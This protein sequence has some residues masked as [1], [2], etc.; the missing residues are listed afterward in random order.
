MLNR[1]EANQRTAVTALTVAAAGGAIASASCDKSDS[2]VESD[3]R[4]LQEQHGW[5][6]GYDAETISVA[7]TV[8]EDSL[9]NTDWAERKTP[10]AMLAAVRPTTEAWRSHESPALYQALAQ[11]T[12]ADGIQPISDDEMTRAYGIG[13]ALGEL[14]DSA[15]NPEQALLIID[16][17]GKDAVACAAGLANFAEPVFWMDNW[18]HPRGVVKSE[19]AL[20]STLYYAAELEAAQT[21]REAA[22]AKVIVLDSTRLTPYRD[23]TTEFDNRY[24]AEVPSAEQARALGIT[25]VIYVTAS[26]SSAEAD[27]LNDAFVDYSKGMEVANVSLDQFAQDPEEDD[28]KGGGYYYGGSSS[29]HGHFYRHHMFF[30]FIPGGRYRMPRT[31]SSPGRARPSGYTPRARQTMFSSRTTG[32]AASGVGRTRPT[33]FGR[34]THGTSRGGGVANMR[35]GSYG[36]YSS[37]VSG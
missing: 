19:L 29:S 21:A 7:P 16:L 22:K 37:G 9:G 15:E 5:N 13:R 14:I 26:D 31:G 32:S 4:Q 8:S 27:D 25:K 24:M 11:P 17:P 33:G 10:E 2:D 12:L 35:S 36:R 30:L 34:I 1:R 28:D 6:V 3:A 23:A 18:P 20:A